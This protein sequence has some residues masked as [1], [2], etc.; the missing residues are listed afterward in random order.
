MKYLSVDIETTGLDPDW[1]EILQIGG[2]VADTR[3]PSV[4][5]LFKVDVSWS[6]IQGEPFGLKMNSH[7]LTTEDAVPI[8]VAITA[9]D[10]WVRSTGVTIFGGKN[11]GSFDAPFLKKYSEIDFGYRFIDPMMLYLEHDATEL[12]SSD[13]CCRKARV[14]NVTHDALEDAICVAKLVYVG[15][16]NK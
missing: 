3:S 15:M 13:F 6:R 7:L 2:C 5:Q 11:F 8:D 9:F 4:S 12:P 16:N 14:A 10:A 1:C